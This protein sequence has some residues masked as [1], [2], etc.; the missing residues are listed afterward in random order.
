MTRPTVTEATE[1]PSLAKLAVSTTV[2]PPPPSGAATHT[3]HHLT[4]TASRSRA[5]PARSGR[6]KSAGNRLRQ[7]AAR[8]PVPSNHDGGAGGSSFVLICEVVSETIR[9]SGRTGERG[10]EKGLRPTI[11]SLP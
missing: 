1:P 2:E 7:L 9:I 6:S 11:Q 5:P 4:E 8:G 10:S 3:T